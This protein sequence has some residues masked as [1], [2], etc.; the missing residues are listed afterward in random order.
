MS[1]GIIT[2][3]G[4]LGSD[5]SAVSQLVA[6]KYGWKRYST[7][8]AQRQIAR[9]LGI[10]TN[11]L[12]RRAEQ[13]PTFDD[14]IDSVFASLANSSEQLVIDSRMA[15]HFLPASFKVKLRVSRM[16]AARRVLQ[17]MQ[18]Q[19][20]RYS[21]V[22]EAAAELLRRRASEVFRFKTKYNVDIDSDEP[23]DLVLDTT[24]A[25]L[26]EVADKIMEAYCAAQAGHPLAKTWISPKS[27]LPTKPWG[28]GDEALP[29]E[30]VAVD[31]FDFIQ[32]GH[33]TV[34]RAIQ[35]GHVFVPI[36]RL[37]SADVKSPYSVELTQRWESAHKIQFQDRPKSG[38]A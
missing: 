32:R 2:I 1:T 29:I 24:L 19:G 4:E 8:E 13:D 21:S 15:W 31:G 25:T 36:R 38:Q 30:V 22:E 16:V 12:N 3:T 11:E 17:D 35:G 28:V 33:D 9:D 20:E 18:R 34:S 27:L 14:R 7:G 10:T 37:G 23:F 5:K 26:D 6:S